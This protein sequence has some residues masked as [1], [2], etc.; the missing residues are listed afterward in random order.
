MVFGAKRL[1]C[2]VFEVLNIGTK[3]LKYFTQQSKCEDFVKH[4]SFEFFNHDLKGYINS[5]L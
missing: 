3:D 1:K 4:L 5:S 2:M